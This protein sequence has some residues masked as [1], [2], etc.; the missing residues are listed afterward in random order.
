MLAAN[1]REG[2]VLVMYTLAISKSCQF[3]ANTYFRSTK[4]VASPWPFRRNIRFR[5]IGLTDFFATEPAT[6]R[7]EQRGAPG[8]ASKS[9][10]ENNKNQCGQQEGF[11][12]HL[13]RR[14]QAAKLL[15]ER[16]AFANIRLYQP[17]NDR[18]LLQVL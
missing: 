14:E 16:I 7:M 6:Y 1:S 3:T 8:R 9:T 10:R 5:V 4:C 12:N 13:W 11:G 2:V 17:A 18:L 15:D